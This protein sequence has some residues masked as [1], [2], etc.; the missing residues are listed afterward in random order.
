MEKAARR[1]L[2]G[3]VVTAAV[4]ASSAPG[5]SRGIGGKGSPD[6]VRFALD[7]H[8]EGAGGHVGLA[9]ALLP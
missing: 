6:G 3:D 1:R 7:D 8:Q 5:T 2:H 9:S 4:I